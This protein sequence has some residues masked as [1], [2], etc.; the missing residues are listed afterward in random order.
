MNIGG[1]CVCVRNKQKPKPPAD[2]RPKSFP[3]VFYMVQRVVSKISLA[4][5]VIWI[6]N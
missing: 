6:A 2:G 1:V 3:G 5:T 4:A